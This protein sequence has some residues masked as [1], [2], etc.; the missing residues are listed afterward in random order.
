MGVVKAVAVC[1]LV[2]FG[3]SFTIMT[4]N[5]DVGVADVFKKFYQQVMGKTSSG[6]TTLEVCYSSGLALGILIFFNHVGRK[7]VTHDPTPMQVQ[8]QQIRA[9]RGHDLY[10][11]LQQKGYKYRCGLRMYFSVLSV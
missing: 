5:N 3:S 10:R 11:K 7:K 6:F 9:G 4:F 1:I 8:M 2:F